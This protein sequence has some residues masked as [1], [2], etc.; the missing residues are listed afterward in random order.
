MKKNILRIILIILILCWM[1]VVFGFSNAGGEEST[2]ISMRI[3][4]F[5]VKDKTYIHFVEQIIRKIAHLSEY[6]IGG[7]LVYGLFLTFNLKSKTQFIG[8]WIF[9]TIYAITDEVHQLFIPGRTGK[10]TDVLIDSLGAIIG[11]CV[12]LLIVKIFSY[13]KNENKIVKND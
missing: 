7:F 8:S 1:Y 13:L 4:E 6:A 5:F 11:I 9:I 10:V 2:G 12:L 3:A